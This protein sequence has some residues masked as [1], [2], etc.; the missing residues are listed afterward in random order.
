MSLSLLIKPAAGLCNIR[1]GYC[2]Y[3]DLSEPRENK[4]MERETADKLIERA[5]ESGAEHITF[6]F[7]GGEPTL[8]GLDFFEYFVSSANH[9]NTQKTKINYSIQTNGIIIDREYAEFFKKNNFL[10]GLSVDGTKETHDFFRTD[11]AGNGTFAKVIKCA[12]L[13]RTAGVE[14][15]ILT[16]VTA[17]TAKHIK[18]IYNFYKKQRFFYLQFITC[19]EPLAQPAPALYSLTPELYENFLFTLFDLWYADLF[20]GEY[21]SIRFFDNLVRAAAGEE[22]ELCG[23]SADGSCPGQFVT[24]FDGTVYPCDFYCTEKW[25]L[26]NVLTHSFEELN[27]SDTMQKFR[28]SSNLNSKKCAECEVFG[29]CRGGC[30]RDREESVYNAAG[31]NKYCAALYKFLNYAKPKL[32]NV[33]TA[34]R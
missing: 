13:L 34:L 20:A 12:E 29:L 11:A 33:N 9:K 22:C 23:L 7:Q 26:G 32:I 28:E 5:F 31:E 10:V 1:C 2:F 21:V 8:A 15:N 27:N 25:R 3:R 4:I 16:V 14:Y 19:L 24:E 30:R 6:A 17:Q 18:K